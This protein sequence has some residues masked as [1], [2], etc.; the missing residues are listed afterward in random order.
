[1]QLVTLPAGVERLAQIPAVAGRSRACMVPFARR[2]A[3]PNAKVAKGHA[4]RYLPKWKI[5][6]KRE[7]VEQKELIRQTAIA[8]TAST[9]SDDASLS[10]PALA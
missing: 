3:A 8:S 2:Q 9:P 5:F 6:D 1:M 7:Q 4:R 10:L